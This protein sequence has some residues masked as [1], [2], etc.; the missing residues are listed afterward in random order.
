M[1]YEGININRRTKTVEYDPTHQRGVDTREDSENTPF[2]DDFDYD[3]TNVEVI[4]IFVRKSNSEITNNEK[5]LDGNPLLH[6]LKREDG[7]KISSYD[8]KRIWQQVKKICQNFV[9]THHG[10]TIVLP[11]KSKV[12]ITLAKILEECDSNCT[13]YQDVLKKVRTNQIRKLLDNGKIPLRELYPKYYDFKR[14]M[15]IIKEDLDKMDEA[16]EDEIDNSNFTEEIP[17]YGIFRVHRITNFKVRN[18]ITD[19]LEFNKE[20]KKMKDAFDNK[21]VIIVDDSIAFG[22]TIKNAVN[23]IREQFSPKSLTVLTLFSKKQ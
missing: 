15:D 7:W 11:S 3:L 18:I 19:F 16:V 9:K 12:N 21:D 20:Y 10:P 8:E 4:S 13:I 14:E 2:L 17:Q 22:K 23:I 1:L 6:A 5:D